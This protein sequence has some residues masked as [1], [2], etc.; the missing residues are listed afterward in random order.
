MATTVRFA[1]PITM[2][3]ISYRPGDVATVTDADARGLIA[4]GYARP[5]TDP[6]PPVTNPDPLPQ[7]VL[8]AELS[9]PDSPARTA[10]A[11]TFGAAGALHTRRDSLTVAVR[12]FE[13][14]GW[15]YPGGSGTV[16]PNGTWFVGVDLYSRQVRCLPRNLHRGW[17]PLAKVVTDDAGVSAVTPLVPQVPATRLPRFTTKVL[18]GK[19]VRVVV[20][21]S[22]LASGGQTTDWP[23]ML[24]NLASSVNDYRIPAAGIT[25][26]YA[27]VGGS[28]NAYQLAQVGL[29]GRH[30]SAEITD[31]GYVTR[32]AN[33]FRAARF[34]DVD[35]VVLCCLANGGEQRLEIIETIVRKLRALGVEVLLTTDNAQGTTTDNAALANTALYVDG[36]TVR[37]IADRY[38]CELAD[39]AAYVAEAHI[40]AGGTGIYSDSIHMTGGAPAGKSAALPSSGHEAWAR[41]VRSPLT[42]KGAQVTGEQFPEGTFDDASK[43]WD[44]YGSGG[45]ALTYSIAGGKLTAGPIGTGVTDS[46]KFRALKG[47]LTGKAYVFTVEVSEITG[48]WSTGILRNS[49]WSTAPTSVTIS[50]PGTY[51]FTH[52]APDSS[53]EAGGASDFSV[54]FW[55]QGSQPGGRIV[56]DRISVNGEGAPVTTDD[57]PLR[58]S[59]EQG[60]LPPSRVVTDRKIPGDA[61]VQLPKDEFVYSIGS[62]NRGTLGA[63]PWGS[64]S[65]ARK[66][67]GAAVGATEDLLTLAVGQRV[68]VSGTN[69]TAIGLIRYADQNDGPVTVDVQYGGVVRKALTFATPPFG[70]EWF[71]YIYT[72]AEWE[73]L[74]GVGAQLGYHLGTQLTVTA[75]T[76]KV[77]ALVAF[78]ADQDYLDADEIRYVGAWTRATSRTGLPGYWSDTVGDRALL[79]APAGSR[80]IYWEV[81][82]NPNSKT[83]LIASDMEEAASV[84]MSG[85]YHAYLRGGL[86]GSPGARHYLQVA[87]A[88]AGDATNGWSAHVAGAVA[89]H[90]R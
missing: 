41:A 44:A 19:A 33:R 48:T 50:A 62:A 1:H 20:L 58:D 69:P 2:Y 79:R 78:T 70:N 8:E 5:L 65:F 67:A 30:G 24:F 49:V 35:L 56:I 63:H 73:T 71:H 37:R 77:A 7:Y 59:T 90:D 23:G 28:P 80:R 66:H 11:A 54:M 43:T 16:L 47:L 4:A 29:A 57:A 55:A 85:N 34:K 45:A 32:S 52:T 17:V 27:G 39:T 74:V 25:A 89:V 75:G 21:G 76:L 61:F 18:T 83:A 68:I 72:P 10:L 60:P 9:D 51:T 15:T 3:G 82:G 42:I 86:V 36:P 6:P 31:A 87:T 53:R 13:V 84:A 40:R 64:G 14:D 22:S 46:G 26:D 12:A 88:A 81:S 38:G